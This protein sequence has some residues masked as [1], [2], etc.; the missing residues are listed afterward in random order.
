ML[1]NNI[2][3]A[4]YAMLEQNGNVTIYGK[5][6]NDHFSDIS[7]SSRTM[8]SVGMS[9]AIANNDG[10][11]S[12]HKFDGQVQFPASSVAKS[13][14]TAGGG[15]LNAVIIAKQPTGVSLKKILTTPDGNYDVF[16]NSQANTN[17]MFK[18]IAIRK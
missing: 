3:T 5:V 13:R 2:E 9:K 14:K 18:Y 17:S 1:N 7:P 4:G 10:T 15:F 12:F 16:D 8:D 6:Y 11:W